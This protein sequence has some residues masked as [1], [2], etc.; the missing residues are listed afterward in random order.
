[1]VCIDEKSA[2]LID[3]KHERI[4]CSP[5]KKDFEY[6]RNELANVFCGIEPLK[7]KY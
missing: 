3:H 2:S 1:V 6:S 5:G 4:P 7:G